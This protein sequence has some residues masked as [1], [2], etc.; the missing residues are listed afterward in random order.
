MKK[1]FLAALFTLSFSAFSQSY[2]V[3]EN[4]ITLSVD[5]GGY[6]YD[7]AHYTP[8]GRVTVKG[9]QY[10]VEDN[11]VLV[12]VDEKGGLFRKYEVLPKQVIGKGLNY[13][14]GD[15]GSFYGI[16]NLGYVNLVEN[17][18]KIKTANRFGGNFFT[19]DADEIFCVT[20][21]GKFVQAVID[22]LKASDIITFGG[23][24]FMTNR[25]VLYTVTADGNLI[26]KRQDRVGII[27]KKGGNYFVDTTGAVY[28][29][30]QDGSLKM[31]GLPVSLRIQAM[32]KLGSNYFMDGSGKLFTVD[33]EGNVFER[34]ISHDLKTT[35]IISL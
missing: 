13:F 20:K 17:D 31:P 30:A 2:F 23:N 28:T 14:I 18:A 5:T 34:W 12:T 1:I 19:T 16:D 11:N 8:V 21:E 32:A 9:G 10:L 27:V 35:K 7:F 6:V 15:N 3:L 33:S 29:V 26:D 25:G 22:G 24:Y 4:G